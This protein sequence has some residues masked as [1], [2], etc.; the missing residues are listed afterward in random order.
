MKIYK[1]L[2]GL[3]IRFKEW[4]ERRLFCYYKKLHSKRGFWFYFSRGMD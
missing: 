2:K 1:F 3:E 4:I